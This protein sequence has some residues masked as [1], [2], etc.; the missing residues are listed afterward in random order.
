MANTLWDA[1]REGF[2]D[3]S[4]DWNSSTLKCSLVRGYIFSASHRFLSDLTGAGGVLVTTATLTTPTV[5][6][7]VAGADAVTFESVPTGTACNSLIIYQAS[8]PGG[9][10][11]LATTAQRLIY[12]IDTGSG[13][14]VTPNGGN[15]NISWD[16]GP[17][18]IF[19]L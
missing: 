18:K 2:L 5:T 3:G 7:G 16:A 15:I 19:K 8:A 14:P 12:F 13:L 6:A 1:G 11:D 9:G 10:A 4:I 17:N